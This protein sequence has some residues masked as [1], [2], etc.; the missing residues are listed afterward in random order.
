MV[1][2]SEVVLPAE[3]WCRTDRELG[4]AGRTWLAL[5]RLRSPALSQ[6]R[7][8]RLSSWS[9]DQLAKRHTSAHVETSPH[10][11]ALVIGLPGPRRNRTGSSADA[12]TR[13]SPS[14]RCVPC[15]ARPT[16]P[17]RRC[18]GTQHTLQSPSSHSA[19]CGSACC[20]SPASQAPL[21]CNAMS[22]APTTATSR[23]TPA[24]LWMAS[25]CKRARATRTSVV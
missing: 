10:F 21:L 7:R 3:G 17:S 15:G 18:C 11:R 25:H 13:G 8:A 16:A 23:P 1:V 22:A 19:P 5:K 12:P 6:A 2:Q 9:F 4:V 24:I 14:S 20:P